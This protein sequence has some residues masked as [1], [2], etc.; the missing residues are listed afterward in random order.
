MIVESSRNALHNVRNPYQGDAKK[1][2][3]V[4]SAGLLRSPTA[5]NV[6][7]REFGYNTRAAGLHDY[8]LI[9]ISSALLTWAD[10]VVVMDN[11]QATWLEEGIEKIQLNFINKPLIVLNIPDTFN[12]KEET[13]QKRIISAYK[14][15]KKLMQCK[16]T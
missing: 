6:L 15:A 7:H 14:E 5:A 8:A 16:D 13:L 1:V 2:L 10:E 12:Y 3:C 4:C 11:D 9:P